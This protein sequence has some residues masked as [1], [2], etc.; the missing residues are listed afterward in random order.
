MK[1]IIKFYLRD[2][3]TI[4]KE[5]DIDLLARISI[6]KQDI[7]Q[8]KQDLEDITNMFLLKNYSSEELIKAFRNMYNQNKKNLLEE[9]DDISIQ[10]INI[11]ASINFTFRIANVKNIFRIYNTELGGL[12]K[13]GFKKKLNFMV[14]SDLITKDI[15]KISILIDLNDLQDH[16]RTSKIFKNLPSIY[17]PPK[18]EEN[19]NSKLKNN[20]KES[21]KKGSNKKEKEI[22]K[23]K[24]IAI[25]DIEKAQQ[26]KKKS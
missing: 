26:N 18:S 4:L 23:R 10:I 21:V 13:E 22:K 7:R 25:N 3:I 19:D 11:V 16:K 1:N 14:L 17:N 8:L 12:N 2:R 20:N 5:T 15:N 24:Y 6:R 9:C